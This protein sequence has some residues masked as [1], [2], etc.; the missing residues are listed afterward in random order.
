MGK[1]AYIFPGQGA[2]YVGMGRELYNNFEIVRDT[3]NRINSVVD[4]NL[5]DIIFNGSEIEL[6]MTENTQPAILAISVSIM[7]LLQEKGV[8]ADAAVGLSLGEYCALVA[9]NVLKFE[10]AL[11][12]VKKRGKF[13]QDAVPE[14]TGTMAAIIGLERE[15]LDNILAE[16]LNYGIVDAV[17]YNCPGQIAI[18]GEIKA[19]EKAVELSKLSGAGR[20]VILQ[21]S[22]PFHSSMLKPAGENLNKELQKIDFGKFDIP[23]I[24]NVDCR[25]YESDKESIIDK[26]TKQVYNAVFFEDSIIELI[27]KGFDTFIEVGPG[28]TLSGFVKRINKGVKILN[29]EDN[30]SLEKTIEVLGL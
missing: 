14:G 7:K 8:M 12:L 16:A 10:D 24:A 23:V 3:L 18:A 25:F 9:A 27:N 15:A 26:L 1:I 19:V 28:R 6:K 5:L 4:F 29:V 13:M 21:V 30:K 17:N 2:Q 11:L 22:A 20:S